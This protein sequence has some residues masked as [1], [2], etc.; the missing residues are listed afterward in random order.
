M[1]KTYRFLS[2]SGANRYVYANTANVFDTVRVSKN[3]LTPRNLPAIH[4]DTVAL[5]RLYTIPDECATGCDKKVVTIGVRVEFSG[6]LSSKAEKLQAL[7]DLYAIVKS[8]NYAAVFDGFPSN[9][10]TEFQIQTS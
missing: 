8:S 2:L 7:E 5:N 3:I 4:Q 10:T 1:S 9:Q 6:P